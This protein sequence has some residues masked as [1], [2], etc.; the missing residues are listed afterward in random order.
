MTHNDHKEVKLRVPLGTYNEIRALAHAEER[1]I[2]SWMR[3]ALR[4]ECGTAWADY[5]REE[6]ELM[7]APYT[8]PPKP[9]RIPRDYEL[10][11]EQQQQKWAAL[12]RGEKWEPPCID[13]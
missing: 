8:E 10:T 2:V 4:S 11:P 12:G 3:R 5:T 6:R 7:M 13:D 9:K 1:S